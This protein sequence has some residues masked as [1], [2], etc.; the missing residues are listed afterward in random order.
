M[1]LMS[2]RSMGIIIGATTLC[3]IV[4]AARPTRS[5]AMLR[6]RADNAASQRDQQGKGKKTGSPK[7]MATRGHY[8]DVDIQLIDDYENS[9][10]RKKP[11]KKDGIVR[12]HMDIDL[13]KGATLQDVTD[14]L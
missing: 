11:E 8:P 1:S 5:L 7:P 4:A 9:S 3:A 13:V 2:S 6:S 14:S 12:I 10:L